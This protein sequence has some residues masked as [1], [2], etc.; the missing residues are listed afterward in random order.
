MIQT[1]GAVTTTSVNAIK[2]YSTA[3]CSE[4]LQPPLLVCTH[5]KLGCITQKSLQALLTPN[6]QCQSTKVQN[7]THYK[8][9]T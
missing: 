8:H 9:Y 3:D 7:C 2:N 4:F 6:V 1:D 5:H